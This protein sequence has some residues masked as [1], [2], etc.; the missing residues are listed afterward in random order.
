MKKSIFLNLFL[1]LFSVSYA[2]VETD[3]PLKIVTGY[4][5]TQV[6]PLNTSYAHFVTDRPVYYFNKPITVNGAIGSYNT[7]LYLQAA[8]STKMTVTTGGKVGIGT[9]SPVGKLDVISSGTISSGS[10]LNWSNAAIRIKQDNYILGMDGNQ[11]TANEELFI[12]TENVNKHISFQIAGDYK[13]KINGNGNVGIGT[14]NPTEKLSVNGTI[15]CKRVKVISDVPQSDFVFGSD[16]R[17]MNL[18][19]LESYVN[20]HSHLPEIPSAQE[21]KENGYNL[22][23]M[24]DLLLRKVE[25]L[26]LYIIELNK[27]IEEL[28]ANQKVTD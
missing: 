2:Q 26:T 5:Y 24:D 22:G 13:L 8:R 17:L 6:G 18:N 25:Q 28:E 16:Y 21:F 27:K 20:T 19:E 10:T 1:V 9:T 3:G 12:S 7:N 4:G 23:E 15:L 14:T 11:I